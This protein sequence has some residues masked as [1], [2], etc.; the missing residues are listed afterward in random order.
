MEIVTI[1]TMV[2][3][4]IITLIGFWAISAYY[5]KMFDKKTEQYT[6]RVV[7]LMKKYEERNNN[8]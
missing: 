4:G 3:T 8:E 5:E 6:E 1:G 7:E 2:G